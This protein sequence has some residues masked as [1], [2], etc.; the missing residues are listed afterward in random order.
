MKRSR[1]ELVLLLAALLC[2][3]ALTAFQVKWVLGEAK[4]QKEEFD[5]NVRQALEKIELNIQ[6]FND[7]PT[8]KKSANSCG[9]L[10][11]ALNQA[12]DLDSLIKNDLGDHG[13]NLDYQYG[14][15]NVNLGNYREPQKGRTVTANL[16]E[17][18]RNSG[19]ELKINFPTEGDF[20]FAQIGYTFISSIVLIILL[21]ISFLMIYRFYRKEKELT[22]QIRE[23]INNMTHEFKTPLTNIAFA[24]NMVAKNE[25]VSTDEKLNSY[26]RI[27]KSEQLKLNERIERI[28]SGFHT[29]KS[30]MN[31][32]NPINLELV[33]KAVISLYQD[34]I[35]ENQG[36]IELITDGNDFSCVCYEDFLH[37]IL[38]NLID[39]AI[40]YSNEKPEIIVMLRSSDQ[41]Y[42]IE[43]SDKGIG[44]PR[45]HQKHIF[46]QYY[47]VPTGDLHDAKGF[48]I[49]LFHVRQIVEQLGG[50]VKVISSR[51][52][53]SR[54]IVE[55]SRQINK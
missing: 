17:E 50:K 16:A 24:N 36:K 2:L 3:V 46:E 29:E 47:R 25:K 45:E 27:I 38:G 41:S 6:T 32:L 18:L 48:G 13:I 4:H 7:C 54:F 37:I 53:G 14:I 21:I 35:G 10:F 42:I 5:T 40:K 51:S 43:V 12:V 19:Y 39:N 22:V 15:V 31:D 49:G 8:A 30:R 44:I 33:A 55:W 11:N 26:T 23:F 52:K 20:I 9:I 34:Q 1:F 28:L